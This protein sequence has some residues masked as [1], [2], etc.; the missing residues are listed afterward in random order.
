MLIL[1]GVAISLTIG[2]HGILN[3]AKQAG[4]ETKEKSA[5]EKVELMLEDYMAEKY[6]GTKTLEEYLNEQKTKGKLDEVTNNGDGT[7]T[8]EV[9]GYEITIKENDLSIIET[10]KAGLKPKVSDI[11]I[12]TDGTTI[13]EDKGVVIGTPLQIN[14]IH[15]IQGGITS[16]DKKLPYTT[17]GSG[18]DVI[19]TITGTVNGQTYTRVLTISVQNKYR[20]PQIADVVKKG[21]FINYSVGNWTEE[22]INKLGNSYVPGG[23]QP[24]QHGKF[25]GFTTAI[26]KDSSITTTNGGTSQYSGWRVLS[27]NAD[28]TVNIIHAG[29]P[30]AYY[31]STPG[32]SSE[33]IL[34]AR[35]WSMYEDC[36]TNS[37]DSVFAV[38][39]SAHCLTYPEA[40]GIIGA[41]YSYDKLWHTGSKYWFAT[42]GDYYT[43]EGLRMCYGNESPVRFNQTGENLNDGAQCLGV[44]PVLKIKSTVK[45]RS[46]SGQTTHTTPQ[47]AWILSLEE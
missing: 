33:S 4:E 31:H 22:D 26:S 11:K 24:T 13:V 1:A 40:Y 3:M 28:G 36:S 5:I 23:A 17:D 7:I 34:K 38:S 25:G 29:T 45:V 10:V 19:F 2:E 20:E 27:T 9:D 32:S 46:A 35:D 18:N 14:F 16:V 44:R 12:T 41:D 30:E 47:T 6:T 42:R 15:S 39:G 21:D 37:A 8:V 43:G